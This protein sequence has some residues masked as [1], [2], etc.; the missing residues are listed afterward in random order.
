MPKIA[1]VSD[2][3]NYGTLLES[4][5]PGSPVFLTRNGRGRYA[6]LDMNDYDRIMA[7]ATLLNALEDGRRSGEEEG[8]ISSE[9]ARR[10]FASRTT[11][12]D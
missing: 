11:T 4:V 3:R 7:Q 6:L 9:E 12:N 2:L 5:Q 1:P 8:W 10:H